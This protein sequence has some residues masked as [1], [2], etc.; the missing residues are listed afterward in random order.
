[1]SGILKK[2]W[3][4]KH[5]N[6]VPAVLVLFVDLNWSEAAA[7]EKTRSCAQDSSDIKSKF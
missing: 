1:V 7:E 4:H 3:I 2:N 6:L 5:Q